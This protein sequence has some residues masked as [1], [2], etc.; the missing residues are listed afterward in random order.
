MVLLAVYDTKA[1]KRNWLHYRY[2]RS[3]AVHD[4]ELVE[5]QRTNDTNIL[6]VY[7]IIQNYNIETMPI[8]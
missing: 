8:K 7:E 4:S 1:G 6:N 3:V 2:T 5:R